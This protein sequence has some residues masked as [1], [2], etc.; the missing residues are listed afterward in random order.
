[1]IGK[2]HSVNFD[3]RYSLY[4]IRLSQFS[5]G[6]TGLKGQFIVVAQE[7]PDGP[8]NELAAVVSQASPDEVLE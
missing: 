5:T 4:P 3:Q 8:Q 6:K 2:R 1:L 7:T